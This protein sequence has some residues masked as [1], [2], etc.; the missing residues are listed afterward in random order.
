[1][2]EEVIEVIKEEADLEAVTD[3]KNTEKE[4]QAAP[5]EVE[6]DE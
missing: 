6:T 3:I 5:A 2:T 1:M 4:V